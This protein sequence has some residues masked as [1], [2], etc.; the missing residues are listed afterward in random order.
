MSRPPILSLVTLAHGLGALS[1]LAVAPLAPFLLQA[2]RLT[3]AQ[4]GWFLPSTA[5]SRSEGWSTRCHC[6]RSR[7]CS[8][9][10]TR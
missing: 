5:A 6:R 8:A 7:W 1:V 3:R 4:V 9:G 10:G 2:L